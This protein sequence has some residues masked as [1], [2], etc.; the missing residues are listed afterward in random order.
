M[1][2]PS[3]TKTNK[4][5]VA[6]IAAA[7][8]GTRLGAEVPKAYVELQ[9]RTLLE[10]SVAAMAHSGVVKRA[11]VTVSP[12]MEDTARA[13][14]A[15]APLPIT[16]VHGGGERADSV[17][18]GLQAI[19]EEDAVVLIHDAARALTPPAMIARVAQTVLDGAPAVIPVLPVSDTIKIVDAERVVSTPERSSLRAVQTP[20]GFDLA[21]LRG[22]NEKYFSGQQ[23]FIA[24]DD[25]SLMEWFGVPV[26]TVPG[27]QLALKITT[28]MDLT[29]ATAILKE[30]S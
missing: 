28:P 12:V 25:A 20:Q 14:L 11:V 8:M 27:D 17:W 9:G 21:T 19:D 24:T 23:E 6:L 15:D 22:A 16:F 10:R 30:N 13:L 7:G 18:A 26:A 29:L 1:T 2:S 4:P 3:T 5:V